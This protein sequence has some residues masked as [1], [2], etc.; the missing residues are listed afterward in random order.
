MA[1]T[2]PFS[3]PPPAPNTTK[4]SECRQGGMAVKERGIDRK[5][6][7]KKERDMIM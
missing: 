7:I 2:P 1:R 3:N 6:D 5:R 4:Q